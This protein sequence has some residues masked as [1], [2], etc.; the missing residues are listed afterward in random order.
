[1]ALSKNDKK[2]T[3]YNKCIEGYEGA[4]TLIIK[5]LK[6]FNK[7]GGVLADFAGLTPGWDSEIFY[8]LM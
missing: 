5:N 4:K 2:L 1:M 7:G 6:R 8:F 3:I